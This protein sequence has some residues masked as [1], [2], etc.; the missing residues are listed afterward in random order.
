MLLC[1]CSLYHYR[2]HS[3][4]GYKAPTHLDQRTILQNEK[5]GLC[6]SFACN[7]YF[8]PVVALVCICHTCTNLAQTQVW[9]LV[10]DLGS[11]IEKGSDSEKGLYQSSMDCHGT[12]HQI[13][14]TFL[15]PNYLHQGHPPLLVVCQCSACYQYL[16]VNCE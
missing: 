16:S 4:C 3:Y 5:L 15:H 1:C 12:I 10:L 7:I 13:H 9:V 6:I 8:R 11:V 14:L 2:Y